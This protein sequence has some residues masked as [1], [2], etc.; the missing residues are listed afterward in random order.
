[1]RSV[2]ASMV[3]AVVL[4]SAWI[5]FAGDLTANVMP[6]GSLAA[7][8]G[9]GHVPQGG[10][11]TCASATVIPALPY[12]DSGSTVGSANDYSSCSG[13]GPDVVYAFTPASSLSVDVSLC[14]SSS[15][16]DTVLGVFA[17]S[18]AGSQ[19]GCDDDGCA[20]YGASILRGVPLSAGTTYYFVVGGWGGDS[21][22]YVIDIFPSI[23][24]PPG[25]TPEP[26]A[27]CGLPDDTVNGGCNS[28]PYVFSPISCGQVIC[29]SAGASGGTRD[30]D[31][32][33]FTLT[34]QT[35]VTWRVTPGFTAMS[36]IL[37][38]GSGGPPNCPSHY[39]A[40]YEFLDAGVEGALTAC[41]PAGTWWTFVAPASYDDVAC[42]VEYVAELDCDSCTDC[43]G[44]L[45]PDRFEPDADG[46]GVPDDCDLCAG[47]PACAVVDADGCPLDGDNDGVADGCD[48]CPGTAAGDP[49]DADG[50]S[51]ADDDGDGV[52]NDQD[53]CAG[54]P[55]CATNVDANGCA[56]DSDGDGNVD[57][58]EPPAQSCCGATGPVAPLG[59]AV[60]MLL[61]S[62]FAGWKNARRR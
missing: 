42:G 54:T 59:L 17:G 25:A 27:D 24:C 33:E 4:G 51:T 28:T 55:T 31:W 34:E 12:H 16:F 30:T 21:G 62:R 44:N 15:G 19:Y 40:F 1:M 48:D 26:E 45:I 36:A 20:D 35:E 7:G 39:A 47:T 13:S 2:T 10:G 61:L 52:L 29:G 14:Q 43:N 9:S 58:C 6:A 57:G 3:I 37:D 41:L 50:C 46:D 5:A 56:I 11:D 32:Y 49:V 22:D 53:D 18:C 60:G 38:N 23:D 8:V